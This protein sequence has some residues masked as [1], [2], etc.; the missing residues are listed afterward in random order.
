MAKNFP[1]TISL[2][3]CII[4]MYMYAHVSMRIR[5]AKFRS[6]AM[7]KRKI[8]LAVILTSVIVLCAIAL[9]GC[10][11]FDSNG[12]ASKDKGVDRIQVED[13]HIYLAPSGD[14]SKYV[15]HPMVHPIETASQKVYYRL[16]DNKDSEYLTLSA[17]G[18]V[19]AKKE[20]KNDD[21]ENVDIF[22][23][24][25]SDQDTSVD[26]E[27]TVT[28]ETVSV[29]GITFNPPTKNI[30]ISGGPQK[31]EPVFEPYHASVGRNV[32][33]SSNN[34]DIATVDADGYVTP[35]SIGQCSIW[36]RTPKQGAFDESQVET[37]VTINVVYEPLQ[38]GYTLML[39]SGE[40]SLKQITSS[41]DKI[42]FTLAQNN[43]LTDPNP[44]IVWYVNN[45]KIDEEGVKDSKV[46][47]Y[48]LN[49]PAGEYFIKA[50]L[51]NIFD[52]ATFVSDTIRI[53]KP[54]TSFNADILNKDKGFRV[55]DTLQ[56]VVTYSS[57]AY[58]PDSYTWTLV[59]PNGVEEIDL[60]PAQKG[61]NGVIVADFNYEL[62][63][64]G[65]YTLQ[66]EACVKGRLSGIKSVLHTIEVSDVQKGNDIV[67]VHFDGSIIDGTVYSSVQW[68]PLPYASNYEV[69]I[70]VGDDLYSL[71]SA[72][73]SSGYFGANYFNVPTN[74]AT[75]MDSYSIRIKGARYG[76]TEWYDYDASA[77]KRDV[78]EY[79]EEIIPG[80]GINRYIANL[81]EYGELLNYLTIFRPNVMK[82]EGEDKYNLELYVP[83]TVEDLDDKLY[84]ISDGSASQETSASNIE[85]YRIFATAIATYVE[86]LSVGIDVRTAVSGGAVNLIMA[87]KNEKEPSL[88]TEL[89]LGVDDEYDI[90]EAP[91]VNDY[92]TTP[93]G[94][95]SSLPIDTWK[96]TMQV[97]T[98]NQLYFAVSLGF[99][100]VPVVGSKAEII[101]NEARSVLN[102]I[103]GAGDSQTQK[104]LAIYEWLSLNVQYDYKLANTSLDSGEAQK[105]NSFYLEG[106]FIDRFAVCD[107]IAKAYS[108]MCGMEGIPN[109]KVVGIAGGV[110]H[111]WNEVLLGSRWYA[112]D[113]TWASAK[114]A[115]GENG[116][117]EFLSKQY[118]GMGTSLVSDTRTTFGK[119]PELSEEA[120]DYAYTITLDGKEF[121]SFIESDSELKYYVSTYLNGYLAQEV[122]SIWAEIALDDEYVTE[123]VDLQNV[124]KVILESLPNGT[125]YKVYT[126]GENRICINLQKE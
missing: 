31:L 49:Y 50:E 69:E 54:I 65:T 89:V 55:G 39:T 10:N 38:S 19:T 76:W 44:S 25:V 75:P 120:L 98:S 9:V 52:S 40:S 113:A 96:N 67:D 1:L 35:K 60:P 90:P 71:G 30:T 74:I 15:L 111:A 43:P 93:R 2:A 17:D 70:K 42:T 13:T 83:F 22:I 63:Q 37:H 116:Y 24:V 99:K 14:A 115:I 122:N 57:D 48:I 46:L 26:L 77:M 82:V 5:E 61:E 78:Y 7:N 126:V 104:A 21:G 47:E 27:V 121:D 80:L 64:A 28:I 88:K 8:A 79:F 103:I 118:F 107:G 11:L 81:E 95:G 36:V 97:A 84:P 100:P 91:F 58:P 45:T 101:Y 87:I 66:A 123:K 124:I 4:F 72:T 23:R 51:T 108:L 119:Y 112:V 92:T 109:Y 125:T 94:E 73:G 105:Y 62:P 102:T 59:T 68:K 114:T 53:Y 41:P 85:A 29:T 20:K 106:V 18:T 56:A 12:G 110:G 6:N 32:I 117:L 86:S 16:V 33:Y 3:C 34:T